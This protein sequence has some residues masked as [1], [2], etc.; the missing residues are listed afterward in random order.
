[1]FSNDDVLK[2][3]TNETVFPELRKVFEKYFE[4]KF[5][6]GSI[7]KYLDFRVCRSP[8]GFSI[9]HTVHIIDLLNEWF[10][11]GNFR[12]VDTPFQKY[13]MYEKELMAAVTLTGNILNKAY[14]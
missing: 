9:D 5:Q 7:I 4:I 1:M 13:S 6:E 3:T 11:T 2:T 12:N 8:L 10:P 14:M